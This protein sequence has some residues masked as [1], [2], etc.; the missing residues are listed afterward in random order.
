VLLR[1]KRKHRA[2]GIDKLRLELT[3]HP[4][5]NGIPI[6]QRSAL[7]A[8]LAQF[9]DRLHR[10]R[11]RL[12]RR[13]HAE[14][15]P[16]TA[17]HHV[18]H[19][20]VKGDERVAGIAGAV[21]PFM[22]GDPASGAPLAGCIHTVRRRGVR[23]GIT[24]RTVP[25]DLR[26]TFAMWGLPDAVRMDRDAVFVGSSRLI[27]PGLIPLWLMGLGVPPIIHRAYR[28]TDHAIGERHHQTWTAHVVIDQ[29]YGDV[30]AL[31]AATDAASADRRTCL[32]SRHAGCDGRPPVIAF[33]TLSEPRR[34]DHPDAEAA[35]CDQDRVD[36]SL[37]EWRW[38]RQVDRVGKISLNGRHDR[39]GRAYRGQMVRVRCDPTTRDCVCS[40]A[41]GQEIKRVQIPE[42]QLE[43]LLG[44]N[45]SE[46]SQGGYN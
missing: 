46:P 42:F 18:W 37:A 30:A 43:Y 38:Q 28:P 11:A 23:T 15:P 6:P 21:A 35:L 36:R 45:H 29:P 31:Q 25:A 27:W 19:M 2:W 10:P 40:L 34:A 9:G 7:A 20:D 8:Y 5:L 41:D 1:C 24:S 17:P 4:S 44:M 39:V 33:P 32:P 3:R 16:P 12:T 26:Q 14:V 13:P 22:V